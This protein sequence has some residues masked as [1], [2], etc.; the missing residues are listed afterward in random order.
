MRKVL[1]T[2]ASGFVGTSLIEKI[3][4]SY[5]DI[6]LTAL[7]RNP[8]AITHQRLTVKTGDLFS[9]KDTL[10]AMQEQDTAVYLVHSMLPSAGLD[11]G[12]FQDFDLILAENFVE[13]AKKVGVKDIIYLSGLIPDQEEK[14][15]THLKSRKEVEEVLSSA[16]IRTTI[17]R[18]GII[19][20]KEGSSF[21]MILRLLQKLPLM[22]CPKWTLSQTQ[23]IDHGDLLNVLCECIINDKVK[24]ATYDLGGPERLSYLTLMK[25][26][27]RFF[28]LHRV[29]I[30]FPVFSLKLSRLWVSFFTGWPKELVYPLILSLKH[31]MVVNPQKAFP[32]TKLLS[33]TI[34]ESL[35]KYGY[36]LTPARKASKKK[37]NDVR[38]IQRLPLPKGFDAQEISLEYFKWLPRFFSSLI[39]VYRYQESCVFY[40]LH[41]KFKLLELTRSVERSS[42]SRQLL[43]ITGGVLSGEHERGRLEFREVL[44]RKYIIAAIHDFTPALPWHLYRWTQAVVHLMVMRAFKRYLETLRKESI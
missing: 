9:L 41:P 11:Q 33:T 17:L 30:P 31:Q 13:T 15:S 23:P 38:S 42:P 5:P 28:H 20:G 29:F 44:N 22:I 43:Y 34:E 4:V 18:A 32:E 14:L 35:Q 12:S 6:H 37:R 39:K 2:G 10:K 8:V 26:I 1:I 25:R 3:L 36:H 16:G 21:Q 27:A 24:G 19:L 7:S 40:F